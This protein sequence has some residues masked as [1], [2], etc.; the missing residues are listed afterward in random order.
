MMGM[1]PTVQGHWLCNACR[2][3]KLPGYGDAVWAKFAAFRPWPARLLHLEEVP[4]IIE[5]SRL[6]Q[7]GTVAVQFFATNEL[8]WVPLSGML[9]FEDLGAISRN[10]G[11]AKRYVHVRT[12]P[13]VLNADDASR[14]ADWVLCVRGRTGG[15]ILKLCANDAR[16]AHAAAV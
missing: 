4:S 10:S 7:P 2:T 5:A 16:Q 3:G 12:S 6:R 15:A 1:V 8:Q 13:A 11:S 9:P 14:L